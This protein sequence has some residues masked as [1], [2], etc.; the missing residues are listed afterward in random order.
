MNNN[1]DYYFGGMNMGWWGLILV[2]IIS[3]LGWVSWSRK[4]K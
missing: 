4:R 2:V 1:G 3:I